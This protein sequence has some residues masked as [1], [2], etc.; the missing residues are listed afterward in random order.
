MTV[1]PY[2]GNKYRYAHVP[3]GLRGQIIF[4]DTDDVLYQ[5]GNPEPVGIVTAP[6][7]V[8][9]KDSFWADKCTGIFAPLYELPVFNAGMFSMDASQ[10]YD[11]AQ[12]ILNTD[13]ND[14]LLFNLWLLDKPHQ[15]ALD[16]FCPFYNNSSRCHL[17]GG[18]WYYDTIVPSFVHENGIKGY[19]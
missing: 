19:L 5:G 12:F 6:E 15:P 11:L 17:E 9:H 18:V 14:Q 13:G 10:L 2:P 4:T 7:N 3:L 16:I 8:L 1:D